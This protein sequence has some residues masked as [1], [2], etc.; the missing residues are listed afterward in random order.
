[1]T[2]FKLEYVLFY[3]FYARIITSSIKKCSVRLLATTTSCTRSSYTSSYK[4]EL[5]RT[6]ENRGKPCKV[7]KEMSSYKDGEV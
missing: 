1:M 3:Q 5:S 4:K 7:C 6:G 2:V